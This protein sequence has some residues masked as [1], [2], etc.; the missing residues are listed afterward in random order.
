MTGSRTT[1]PSSPEL[2]WPV[3]C[4]VLAQAFS[5]E[6]PAHTS[7]G[8]AIYLTDE[9]SP[10]KPSRTQQRYLYSTGWPSLALRLDLRNILN[11]NSYS[12]AKVPYD[13][14]ETRISAS[15]EQP[16]DVHLFGRR[17]RNRQLCSKLLP[18]C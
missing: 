18:S 13:G 3:M 15:A 9:K 7:K 16:Y 6:L 1:R 5:R 10:T 17:C 4:R 14:E 12:P 11:Q 2:L 8:L